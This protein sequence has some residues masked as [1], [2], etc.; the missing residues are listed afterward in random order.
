MFPSSTSAPKEIPGLG[1]M[2]EVYVAKPGVEASRL[3]LTPEETRLFGLVGRGIRVADFIERSGFDEVRACELARALKRKGAIVALREVQVPTTAADALNEPDVDLDVAR[4]QDILSMEKLIDT[5]NHYELLGLQP[6][7]S[8]EQIKRASM[9]KSAWYHPDKYF[10]KRLGSYK[11]RIDKIFR[12]LRVAQAVLLDE[13]Q[14]VAYDAQWG[15]HRVEAPLETGREKERRSRLARHPYLRAIRK[16]SEEAIHGLSADNAIV[17]RD[18]KGRKPTGLMSLQSEAEKA[19]AQA[20]LEEE[21]R[22]ASEFEILGAHGDASK[23]W[24]AASNLAPEDVSYAMNAVRTGLVA[25]VEPRSLRFWAQRAV[26]LAPGKGEA[27][28]LMAKVLLAAGNKVM[29]EMSLK[30]ALEVEPRHAEANL[31]SKKKKGFWG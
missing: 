14:R 6:T 30:R 11:A 16:K 5:L 25:S 7:A 2:N 22:R 9:E 31:L 3:W 29:A 17:A 1:Q 19:E 18:G 13:G 27:H 28:V 21:V 20:N 26:D 8:L 4:R 10:G 23:S 15:I 12:R 24:Q